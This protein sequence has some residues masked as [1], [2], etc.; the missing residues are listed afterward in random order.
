VSSGAAKPARPAGAGT[1]DRKMKARLI[2]SGIVIALIVVFA[3]LNLGKVKVDWIV[4]T[5]QTSLTIVIVVAFL[6][7]A[8]TGGLLV[9]RRMKS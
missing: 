8:L 6:L 5:T 7:G 2:A 1:P 3:I 4:A 9:R